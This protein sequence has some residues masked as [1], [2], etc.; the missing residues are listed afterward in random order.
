MFTICLKGVKYQSGSLDIKKEKNDLNYQLKSHKTQ[1]TDFKVEQRKM[2]E[3]NKDLEAQIVV[4][5]ENLNVKHYEIKVIS[6]V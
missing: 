2:Q 5:N 6:E 3:A 4:K 1:L